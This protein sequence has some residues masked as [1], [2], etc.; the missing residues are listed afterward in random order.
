MLKKDKDNGEVQFKAPF[1]GQ[2]KI[3]IM[4]GDIVTRGQIIA[5]ID[6]FEIKSPINCKI[7]SVQTSFLRDTKVDQPLFG[8]KQLK[9]NP[10]FGNRHVLCAFHPLYSNR[11][12]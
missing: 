2:V 4:S 11:G 9:G 7:T 10:S 8:F 6:G 1:T 12:L 3:P 5:V